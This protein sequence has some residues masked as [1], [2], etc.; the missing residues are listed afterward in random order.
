MLKH[1]AVTYCAH[2]PQA[3]IA[4]YLLG[5][6]SQEPVEMKYFFFFLTLHVSPYV[7]HNVPSSLVLS[8]QLVILFRDQSIYYLLLFINS[9]V[10]PFLMEIW[11]KCTTLEVDNK[12]ST[13]LAQNLKSKRRF[14]NFWMVK[15]E[16]MQ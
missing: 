13:S 1:K 8:I 6:Q 4:V 3:L 11:L 2:S 16:K 14:G 5:V 7:L 9:R 10:R 15:N 12:G